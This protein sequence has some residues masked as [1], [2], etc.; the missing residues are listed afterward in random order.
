MKRNK[1]TKLQQEYRNELR[2]YK[3]RLRKAKQRGYVF[4]DLVEIKDKPTKSDIKKLK[5]LKGQKL[6]EQAL[7]ISLDTG[8]L[9][10]GKASTGYRTQYQAWKEENEYIKLPQTPISVADTEPIDFYQT[11]VDNFIDEVEY[12]YST[13]TSSETGEN[14][15]RNTEKLLTTIK[16]CVASHGIKATAEALRLADE[17]GYTFTRE[18]AYKDEDIN[19]YI[20]HI[21]QYIPN[22]SDIVNQLDDIDAYESYSVIQ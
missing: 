3:D 6:Y 10:Q 8:E 22:T 21:L 5:E 4:E 12:Y 11:V 16:N 17:D 14:A 15:K 7:H 20:R 18:L 2:K 9:I 19:N 1:P 13:Y